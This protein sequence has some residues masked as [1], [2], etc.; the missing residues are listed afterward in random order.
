MS[1]VNCFSLNILQSGINECSRLVHLEA[2]FW[3]QYQTGRVRNLENG[4]PFNK[5]ILRNYLTWLLMNSYYKL[6]VF[7][8]KWTWGV[9]KSQKWAKMPNRAPPGKW[10]N[11]NLKLPSQ[12][13]TEMIQNTAFKLVHQLLGDIH[14]VA[15]GI[16]VQHVD[17]F[18]Q[19]ASPFILNC[20]CLTVSYRIDGLPRSKTFNVNYVLWFQNT[21]DMTI[22]D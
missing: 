10:A 4:H 9:Q 1:G 8:K 7:K 12:W 22:L 20:L 14:S 16:V 19:H 5:A 2:E 21:D 11:S 6:R 15:S 18:C 17:F 3:H 13:T